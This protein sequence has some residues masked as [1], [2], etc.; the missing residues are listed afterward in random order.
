MMMGLL[1]GSSMMSNAG[2]MAANQAA[3]QGVNN[4]VG[5]GDNQYGGL[6]GWVQEKLGLDDQEMQDLM[7]TA[8]AS[9]KYSGNT[10][11]GN[12]TQGTP[13]GHAMN[14]LAAISKMGGGGGKRQLPTVDLAGLLGG[15]MGGQGGR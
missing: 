15:I 7:E 11:V 10:A 14:E 13:A 3:S 4:S 2:G 6:L 12:Q 8:A 1:G 9:N 5:Y